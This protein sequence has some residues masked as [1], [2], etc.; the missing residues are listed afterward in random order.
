MNKTKHKF[1]IGK[2]FYNDR[3]V[4]LFSILVAFIIWFSISSTSQETI[5]YNVAEVPITLPELSDDVITEDGH[6]LV[7]EVCVCKD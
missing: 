2:L 1:S 5:L 7:G 4:I 3:F 6:L